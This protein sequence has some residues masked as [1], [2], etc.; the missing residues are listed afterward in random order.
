MR[1]N[2]W[3]DN[4]NVT[5]ELGSQFIIICF[6]TSTS[7]VNSIWYVSNNIIDMKKYRFFKSSATK[8]YIQNDP[9]YISINKTER[10]HIKVFPLF[11]V[12]N[13]FSMGCVTFIIEKILTLILY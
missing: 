7:I 2:T 9:G 6:I 8:L 12:F 11:W 5:L 1:R 3:V 4:V 10:K 13:I